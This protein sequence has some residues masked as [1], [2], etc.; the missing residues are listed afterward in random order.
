[1]RW[2]RITLVSALL[3]ASPAFAADAKRQSVTQTKPNA[4]GELKTIHKNAEGRVVAE[5]RTQATSTPL[6]EI[7][8]VYRDSSGRKIG[9]AVMQAKPNALG[10]MK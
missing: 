1:M 10:E 6:G 2:L 3:A 7:K 9:E 8:T 5:S 4:L